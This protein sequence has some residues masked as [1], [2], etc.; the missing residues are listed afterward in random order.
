MRDKG[1][2]GFQSKHVKNFRDVIYGM[3]LREKGKILWT[4]STD[5]A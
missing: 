4:N 3:P 1:G 2:E 5:L